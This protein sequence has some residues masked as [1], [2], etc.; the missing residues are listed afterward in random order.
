MRVKAE[1]FDRSVPVECRFRHLTSEGN[2]RSNV[3]NE[4]RTGLVIL[5]TSFL[6]FDPKRSSCPLRDRQRSCREGTDNS[7]KDERALK[8]H[9]IKA[10]RPHTGIRSKTRGTSPW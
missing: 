9:W 7:G 10:H 1:N 5:T 3:G 6:H 2:V 8:A 4:V